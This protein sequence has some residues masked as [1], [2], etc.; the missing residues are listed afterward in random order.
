MTKRITPRRLKGFRDF[1][2][3][4]MSHRQRI[5]ETVRSV[6][7]LAC[8]EQIATP[9]L[10]YQETLLGQG[11][12]ETDKQV[13]RFTD[14]GGRDVA[15]RFDLTVPFARFTAEHYGDLVLPFK[16]LQIG[17]VWRGENTQKGRYRQFMQCDLDIIGIDKPAAD[18]EV[19]AVLGQILDQVAGGGVTIH[20]G[21]RQVLVGVLKAILGPMNAAQLGAALIHLDKLA[22]VGPERT[23]DSL[24]ESLGVSTAQVQDLIGI[25]AS[26]HHEAAELNK[27]LQGASAARD[28]YGRLNGILQSLQAEIEIQGLANLKVKV[29]LS[30]A[31]GLGYYTGIVFESTLDDLPGFGSICSGGRYNDLAGRFSSQSLPGVGGSIGLDRLLAGLEELGRLDEKPAGEVFVAIRGEEAYGREL[32]GLLRQGG[33][34]TDFGLHGKLGQQFRQ[35]DRKGFRLVVT[36]GED[37]QRSRTCNL[38]NLTTGDEQTGLAVT[39]LKAAAL[40][41]LQL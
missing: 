30:I 17:E 41:A 25:L 29:D 7:T 13:Y 27:V 33:L 9:A 14:H 23:A 36:V 10:E 21:H 40:K 5:A 12:E 18:L 6:A 15:L 20:L 39:D 3:H 35:A 19:L 1:K 16:K 34:R 26:D 2:P 28:A 31:R 37:E 24:K 8:F 38:K 4:L 22:K 11:G 32:V